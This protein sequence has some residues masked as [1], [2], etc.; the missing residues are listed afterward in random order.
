MV[1][2]VKHI[3]RQVFTRCLS[4][5]IKSIYQGWVFQEGNI[6]C[7]IF[8]VWIRFIFVTDVLSI[9]NILRLYLSL[10]VFL[11][12]L[13]VVEFGVPVN[14]GILEVLFVHREHLLDF[15][16]QLRRCKW[17][18]RFDNLFSFLIDYWPPAVRLRLPRQDVVASNIDISV[19]EKVKLW[20]KDHV[21]AELGGN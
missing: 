16:W 13:F 10:I 12:R 15:F 7:S 4:I 2:S 18:K 19:R 5:G 11:F 6:A 20:I 1:L 17:L 9:G 3:Y 8:S 14:V 21:T